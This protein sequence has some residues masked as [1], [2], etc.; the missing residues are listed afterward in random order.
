DTSFDGDGKQTIEFDAYSAA[1]GV[2]LD[3]QGRIVVAGYTSTGTTSEFAVARLTTAGALDTSFDGD[4][5]QTFTF[6]GWSQAPYGVA[7][8]SWAGV[9]LSGFT[10]G[11]SNYD[12]A[13]AR[14][15]A[16]GALDN[17]FDSDGRQT[18]AFAASNDEEA[19]GVAVD[20]LDRV[21]V[22]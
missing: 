1:Y 16:A 8:D 10:F 14:L 11:G 18:I 20:S 9:T 12:M 21:V 4:G 13:V 7:T 17:G 19:H 6:G 15:T 5:K 2:A 22:A 3:S